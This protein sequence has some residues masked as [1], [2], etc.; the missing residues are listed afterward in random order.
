MKLVWCPETASQAFIAGVSALSESEHGPAGSA[1]VAELVS[2]MAGGWNAQLVV[3]APEVSAPDSAVTSLALAAAAQRTGGRYA[4]VLADADRAM[5]EMDGVDF[6]VVDAR[7]RDAAAV[8]AAARPGP[9]GMVV[10]RHGDGRRR[11]TKALEASM[12]AGTRVVRSVYLPIDKGVEVLH[13]GVGKGPSIQARRSP[14]G[15]NRWI[16]H[17]DQE[18]G[19]EHLFRRQ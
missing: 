5:V 2:A 10:V 9:R 14:R 12:A 1:G 18:T 8:L 7:R 13:V 15:S 19:E 17:V 4:R 6:L 16:R 3:E 11:G